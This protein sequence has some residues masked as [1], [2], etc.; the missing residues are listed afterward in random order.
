M[1]RKWEQGV[2]GHLSTVSI[3]SPSGF[4]MVNLLQEKEGLTKR[5]MG[6]QYM[7]LYQE[8]ERQSLGAAPLIL[9]HTES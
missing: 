5:G 9:T 4:K 8:Y 6:V 2:C 1:R 7:K 3:C